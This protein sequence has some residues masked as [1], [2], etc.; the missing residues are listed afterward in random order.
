MKFTISGVVDGKKV[1]VSGYCDDATRAENMKN[2][3]VSML[4]AWSSLL[5]ELKV[6][7]S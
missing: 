2:Q 1:E 7:T 4:C 5:T 6:E 3:I